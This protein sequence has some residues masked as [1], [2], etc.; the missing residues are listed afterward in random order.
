MSSCF[1]RIFTA[2]EDA[3]V[4]IDILGVEAMAARLYGDQF[5]IDFL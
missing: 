2:L 1:V 3:D 4:L 5:A